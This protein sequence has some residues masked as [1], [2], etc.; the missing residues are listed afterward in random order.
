VLVVGG[1]LGAAALNELVPKALA[2]L[3][4][5]ARPRVTHQ[6]GARHL[7]ALRA[8]YAAAGVAGDLV[9]FIDDMAAALADADVVLC[10]AGAT[11]VAE[12]A[13]AGVPAIL[14]PFPF[15]VDDHQTTNARFLADQGAAILLQQRD[16]TPEKLADALRGFTRPA[17][18]A[19]AEK[20][21]GLGRPAA[22]RA[23]A[24]ACVEL[25]K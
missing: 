11:T 21:R 4:P 20:A 5:D 24:D 6:S 3:P 12:L 7:D 19:M 2:L 23:V 18:A 9:G 16:L 25:A 13:A 10:R 17:L 22:A 1:S 15:A 8:N 14:V